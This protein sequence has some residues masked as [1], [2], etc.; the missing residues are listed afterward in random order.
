M[1]QNETLIP[2]LYVR[3]W[4]YFSLI[5]LLVLYQAYNWVCDELN[6]LNLAKKQKTESIVDEKEGWVKVEKSI[7]KK[8]V[9]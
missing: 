3:L 5:I 4:I 6:L 9:K 2:F 8:S 7:L 1:E